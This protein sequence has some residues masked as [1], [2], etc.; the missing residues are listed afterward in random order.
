[1]KKLLF[2]GA[3]S[4]LLVFSCSMDI[5]DNNQ[6]VFTNMDG[7]PEDLVAW[8]A[9]VS[10]DFEIVL[11]SLGTDRAASTLSW[12]DQKYETNLYEEFSNEFD[13]QPRFGGGSSYPPLMDMPFN[14]D[15]AVY[16][17]GGSDGLVGNVIAWVAPKNL[18]GGFYHGAALDLDKVDPNNFDVPCLQT[19]ITKGAGYETAND[20][21]GKINVAVMNPVNS[22]NAQKLNTAQAALDY[23][24]EPSNTNQEYGFFKN[25]VNI[26]NV[27]TKEDLYTWYCTKVVWSVFDKYGIDIDS[28]STVVD[29][30]KSGLYSLVKSYYKTIYFYS[31]SKANAAINSYIADARE[32]IVLAEEIMLS[33]YL[34]KV[35]EAIRE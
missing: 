3:F 7:E 8:E 16:L 18:P 4:I 10:A 21:R 27:V 2:L 6:S 5:V 19:A 33:P 29:F 32:K 1:M 20:W 26:F 31:P 11:D 35:Y 15:G 28:N 17:S 24:C 14:R 23:Y 9:R 25:K 34:T 13:S 30:T 12:Y 22:L